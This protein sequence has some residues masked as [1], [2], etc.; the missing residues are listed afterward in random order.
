MILSAVATMIQKIFKRL[1]AYSSVGHI[2]YAL[3]GVATLEQ[4]QA[5]KVR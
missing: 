3:A 4:S 1:L 2:G 5:T